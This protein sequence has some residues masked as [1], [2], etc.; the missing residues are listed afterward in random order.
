MVSNLEFMSILEKEMKQMILCFVAKDGL[1]FMAFCVNG[2]W[3]VPLAYF[4][5]EGLSGKE[6]ANLIK[7]CLQRLHDT[8]A[9]VLSITCDGPSCHFSMM[10]DLG[11]SLNP[12]NLKVYFNHPC[13]ESKVVYVFLDICHMLKL[14]RN[15]LGEYQVLADENGNKI[16]WQ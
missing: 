14:V 3:K 13:E 9:D 15:T 2:S 7:V 8:G 6:H 12:R 4:F 11:A 1:V 5:I 10:S 16:L